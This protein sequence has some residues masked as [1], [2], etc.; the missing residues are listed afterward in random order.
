MNSLI[1]LEG[2]LRGVINRLLSRTDQYGALKLATIMLLLVRLARRLRTAA[3]GYGVK[4]WVASI[5]LPYVK[6]I[7]MVQTKL[8]TESE[9]VRAE[10]EPKL[11]KDITQP[12]TTLQREPM[13]RHEIKSLMETRRELDTKYWQD[14]RVT[15]A[16]YHGQQ[17]Y[18]DFVGDI[19]GMFAFTNPL[20][21]AIHPATRQM[22]A[23]VIQMVVNLYNGTADTCGA[24][25][26]G[27]TESILMAM[28]A[29]RDQGLAS[30]ISEPNVVV[31]VTAHAAFDKAAQYFGIQLRKAGTNAEM[32]VDI[33][34]VRRLVDSSTV[35]IVGSAP[36]FA[37]GT[38]D[39]IDSLSEIALARGVG[40]HVD[41][42]LG[43]FL[44]PFMTQAYL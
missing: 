38:I 13:Q 16:I 31:C 30:G 3:L 24:F 35:A 33:E 40:L 1:Q 28:K 25:T 4:A 7:P 2:V 14:G 36:Q 20:H 43:G 12:C 8:R 44:L 6:M 22:E 15:G 18:T 9:K 37:H 19:Y 5:V 42:C 17:D 21:G 23:E 26:T 34:H 39:D 27:G 32:E 29:Y 11:Y 10:L 41:C